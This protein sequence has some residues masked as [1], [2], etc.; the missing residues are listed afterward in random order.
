MKT[1]Q[2]EGGSLLLT[3]EEDSDEMPRSPSW[4]GQSISAVSSSFTLEKKTKKNN[5]NNVCAYAEGPKFRIVQQT[6]NQIDQPSMVV[7]KGAEWLAVD[8]IYMYIYVIGYKN[9]LWSI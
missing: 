4:R 6:C 8:G 7:I 2:Y 9:V 3:R 5:N 1:L